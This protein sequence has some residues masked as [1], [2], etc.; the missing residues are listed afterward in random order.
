MILKGQFLRFAV[1]TCHNEMSIRFG[2]SPNLKYPDLKKFLQSKKF[3]INMR[4]PEKVAWFAHNLW[5]KN[6]IYENLIFKLP[7][8]GPKFKP[9]TKALINLRGSS[10]VNITPNLVTM[11]F[12]QSSLDK[13]LLF[14]SDIY[15][16]VK[17]F[18]HFFS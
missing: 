2:A 11:Q 4:W 7:N 3:W 13:F 17:I 5:S 14:I 16:K 1:V 6:D 8:V 18:S 10:N 12:C 9:K 15:R